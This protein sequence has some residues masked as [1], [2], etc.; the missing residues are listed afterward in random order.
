M[1]ELRSA[2]RILRRLKENADTWKYL[3]RGEPKYFQKETFSGRVSSILY[4]VFMEDEETGTN[5]TFAMYFFKPFSKKP[6][7]L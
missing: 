1:K 2:D 7:S 4:R 5:L 3:F 6:P